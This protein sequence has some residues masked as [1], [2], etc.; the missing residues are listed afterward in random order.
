MLK[1]RI[2]IL[3]Y[4]SSY[5]FVNFLIINNIS[6]DNLVR[7]EDYFEVDI[8]SDDIDKFKRYKIKIIKYYGTL[9]IVDFIKRNVYVLIGLICGLILLY[10]LKSTIFDVKI[11]SNNQELVKI[12]TKSLEEE[13][14][15]KYKR[16][17]SFKE[18]Y[19]VK[20]SILNNN[21]DTLEWIEIIEN[22]CDY[23][24][25]VTERV[26]RKNEEISSEYSDIVANKD[27]LILHISIDNGVKIKDK[28]DYVKKGEVI[29][30]GDIYKGDKLIK[31]T[32]ARGEVFA[33]VWYTT[34]VVIPFNYT[35]YVDTGKRVNHYYIN[36]F[37]K[38]MTILG[39]YNKES[40]MKEKKLILDKP[41][42]FFD[43]YKEVIKVYEY[44]NFSLTEKEAYNEALIRAENN[45]KKSLDDEEYIMY[46]KVLKKNTDNNRLYLEMFFKVYENITKSASTPDN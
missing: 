40:V 26:K 18:L 8:S 16:K 45:I 25:E 14:I 10:L 3:V 29:I 34:K 28:N 27:G 46:K 7:Y 22:G 12:I 21:K 36:A 24:I 35:E 43:L 44:K 30:S 33:E 41:Y 11:N 2:K 38:E 6:Y 39:K 31:R 13:N 23:I 20:E 17:K 5:K 15:Y 37:G 9:G 32:N 4:T 42:L 1:N 19:K